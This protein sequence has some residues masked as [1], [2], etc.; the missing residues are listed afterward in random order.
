MKKAYNVFDRAY[1]ITVVHG[2]YTVENGESAMI[3]I[4]KVSLH[5]LQLLT[6][7]LFIELLDKFW[8]NSSLRNKPSIRCKYRLYCTNQ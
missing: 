8:K 4:N 2:F 1:D 6:M 5:S 3:L 7:L